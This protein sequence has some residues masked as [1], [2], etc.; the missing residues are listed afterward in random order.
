MT[1]RDIIGK[2][3]LMWISEKVVLNVVEWNWFRI[4][5]NDGLFFTHIKTSGS[6]SK[7]FN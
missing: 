2:K 3:I 6:A 4:F 5:P 1:G 7:L